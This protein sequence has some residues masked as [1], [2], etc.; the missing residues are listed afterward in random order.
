MPRK[1]NHSSFGVSVSN[2]LTDRHMTQTDL[3]AKLDVSVG[4][5]NQTMTG[6]SPASPRWAD[7]VADVLKV[8]A[9]QRQEL[10]TAAAID[11]GYKLDL[12]PSPKNRR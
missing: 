8:S 9:T 1:A 6:S 12:T 10:H 4:Y 7:M 3:A 2:V 11:A 5:V